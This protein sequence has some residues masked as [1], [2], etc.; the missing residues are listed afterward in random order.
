METIN[1][2]YL[3]HVDTTCSFEKNVKIIPH[4]SEIEQ[5]EQIEQ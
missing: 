4:F 3:T 1:F 5:I 2:V